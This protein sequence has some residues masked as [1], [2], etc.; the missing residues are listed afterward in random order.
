MDR[1]DLVMQA[2][3]YEKRDNCPNVHQEFFDSN[4]GKFNHP[5]VIDLVNEIKAQRN[6]TITPTDKTNGANDSSSWWYFYKTSLIAAQLECAKS[7]N[8][9][10]NRVR[11][12]NSFTIYFE[13]LRFILKWTFVTYTKTGPKKVKT[14]KIREMLVK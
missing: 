7:N 14:K 6:A 4:E 10:K 1:L 12:K 8:F 13:Y 9:S 5:L 3:E 11:L 2:F